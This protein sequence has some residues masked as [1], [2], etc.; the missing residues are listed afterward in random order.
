MILSYLSSLIANKC[1]EPYDYRDEF[2]ITPFIQAYEIP[3]LKQSKD[4]TEY[5]Y[6]C[7]QI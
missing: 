3:K 1:D 2:A 7:A 6:I 4:S 5:F